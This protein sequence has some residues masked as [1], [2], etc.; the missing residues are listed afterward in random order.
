MPKYVY[1]CEVC[2]GMFEVFHGMREKHNKCD[3]CGE[4]DFVYKVP[5]KT[6]ILRKTKV[7]QKTK[8]NIEENRNILKQM[9]KDAK[10][11]FYE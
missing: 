3:L 4:E 5:Q 10:D 7:G 9:K 8:E 6:S 11:N 1:C 2:D